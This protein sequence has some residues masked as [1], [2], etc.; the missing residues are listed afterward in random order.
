MLSASRPVGSFMKRSDFETAQVSGLTSCPKRWISAP[1][2]IGSR[3]TSPF[4]RTPAGDVL[5]GDH[6]HASRPAAG[7]VDG[8][9]DAL[10][11]DSLFVSGE[12]EI[13]HEVDDVPRGEVLSGV[14]IQRLVEL[15]DQLLEDGPHRRVVDRAGC[16]STFLNRSRT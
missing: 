6:Q 7:V 1:L 11:P 12:H 16:R 5:L 2:W 15:A 13:D 9:D 8:C 3:K 4:R 14:L 10:P